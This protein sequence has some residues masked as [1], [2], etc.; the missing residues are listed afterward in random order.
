MTSVTRAFSS[1]GRGALWAAA[2]IFWLLAGATSWAQTPPPRPTPRPEGETQQTPAPRPPRRVETGPPPPQLLI[3]SDMACRLEIDGEALGELEKDVVSTFRL[4]PGD[5]L[6]QA[7]PLEIEGPTWKKPI[8]APDTGTVA[9]TI[10][11]AELVADWNEEE[12]DKDR[13]EVL[14]NVVV[15]NDTGLVWARNV[16][17]E[18]T[19][20][21]VRGYCGA[22]DL[23]GQGGWRM[24]VLDELSTLQFE[25]HESPRQEMIP[26]EKKWTIFGPRRTDSEVL[27]RLIYP[28]FDHNSVG[29]LW[30][31]GGLE[32][33]ACT[34]LGGFGCEVLRKKKE[35]A[36]VL[37]VRELSPG[38]GGTEGPGGR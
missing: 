24:P 5:H 23:D 19:W 6:L 25:D 3:S 12:K 14:D 28:P 36:A 4:K 1:S 7:F 31:E 10:E 17:P 30:I 26:G 8:S 2:G 27:P 33:T 35:T 15:D 11:L 16:S 22:R 37:C 9:E 38:G 32:R 20:E 13:F 18:M 21:Q 34:F 29:A